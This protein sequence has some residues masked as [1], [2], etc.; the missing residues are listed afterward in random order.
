MKVKDLMFVNDKLPICS[1]DD[2]V[3]EILHNLSAKQCG[4]VL[5]IDEN[6]NLKGLFTDGDLRRSI[7]TFK[8]DFLHQKISNLMTKKYKWIHKEE[9]LIE[10]MKIMEKNQKLVTILPVLDGSKVVGLIRMHD[11][12]RLGLK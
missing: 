5:V 9:L 7:K 3:M 8:N 12:V 10:A 11:I 4:A 2:T 6:N 1:P